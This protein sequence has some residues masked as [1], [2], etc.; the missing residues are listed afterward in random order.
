M[1]I[2]FLFKRG[3]LAKRTDQYVAS[4]VFNGYK[5]KNYLHK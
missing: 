4:F 3:I 1:K 5:F 2:T